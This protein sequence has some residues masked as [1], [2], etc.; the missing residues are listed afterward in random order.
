M[1]RWE[2]QGQPKVT[3]RVE[4]EG[5]LN[6]LVAQAKKLGLGAASIRDAGRTQVTA[7]T[8]TVAAIGP[9]PVTLIDSITGHLKLY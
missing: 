8:K 9:G 3:L 7:G 6:E 5:E 2:A 1:K 4:S